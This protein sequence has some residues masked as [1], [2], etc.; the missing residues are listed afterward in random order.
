MGQRV[1]LDWSSAKSIVIPAALAIATFAAGSSSLLAQTAAKPARPAPAAPAPQTAKPNPA[2][3][4]APASPATT[5]PTEA[6]KPKPFT[7]D[8]V[9]KLKIAGFS[10]QDIVYAIDKAA[11]K[12]FDTSADGLIALAIAG[13]SKPVI[14]VVLGRPYTPAAPP[15]PPTP[16]VAATPPTPLAEAP[17][18]ATAA[19]VEQPKDNGG[20]KGKAT[21]AVRALGGLFGGGKDNNDG[22]QNPVVTSGNAAI[23][24]TIETPKGA[25]PAVFSIRLPADDA[26]RQ[27][28][29]YFVAE[30]LEMMSADCGI[31]QISTTRKEKVAFDFGADPLYRTQVTFVPTSDATEVRV[32]RLRMEAGEGL[33]INGGREG[34]ARFESVDSKDSVKAATDIRTALM[35]TIAANVVTTQGTVPESATLSTRKTSLGKLDKGEIRDRRYVEFEIPATPKQVRDGVIAHYNNDGRWKIQPA[36]ADEQQISFLQTGNALGISAEILTTIKLVSNNITTLI[37][38]TTERRRTNATENNRQMGAFNFEVDRTIEQAQ[39]IEK[40]LRQLTNAGQ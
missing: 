25:S 40:A 27:T 11:N 37:R 8:D 35:T 13:V 24:A 16:V 12:A 19:S 26:C 38:V 21:V 29:R 1:S 22:I 28:I 2:T 39:E 32:K 17:T 20:I 3:K 6:P 9:I 4:P 5:K 7:N 33:S 18:T 31:G 36:S 30:G 10:D 15:V 23:L 34:D 14:G